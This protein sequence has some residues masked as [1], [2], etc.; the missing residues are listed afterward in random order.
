MSNWMAVT[1]ANTVDGHPIGVM[2]PQIGY[3]QPHII[4]E[5]SV[6][7]SGGTP[8]D[9][10]GRGMAVAGI[11]YVLIGRGTDY[12]WS[13]TSNDS[14]HRRHARI[15]DVQ[16]GRLRALADPGQR[17]PQRRRL[18]LR[19]RRR[20]KGP[21]YAARFYKRT[22]S[23][24]A[25]PTVASIAGLGGSLAPASVHRYVL[26]THYGPVFATATVNGAPV[27][28]SSQ[29]STFFGELDTTAPFALTSTPTV[30]GV[31]SFQHLLNGYSGTFNWLYVDKQDVGYSATGLLPVRNAG[32]SPEL[33][34]WG[35]GNYEWAS[36]VSF[37]QQNPYYFSNY[38]GDVSFP[39]RTVPVAQNGGPLNGGY[40]EWQNYLTYA[41]H[42]QVVNPSQGYILSW[43]NSPAAGWWAADNRPNWGPI[44]RID[45]EPKRF[46]QFPA[47]P[48]P[49]KFEFRQCR[50]DHGGFRLQRS[51]RP[52]AVAAAAA[53]I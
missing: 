38:G 37:L 35:N 32:Q 53:V 44:H 18:S 31:S 17:L 21:Q 46:Q 9:L 26:R 23:W 50:G 15:E 42:P 30:H 33:P 51:A 19:R 34:S 29:R 52:E 49:Q 11:P 12:A 13:A 28:I 1:A 7:S 40:Y 45:T 48:W 41:Q 3:F 36:D 24:T 43:N 20:N 39:S 4:W 16:H 14:D 25:T 10:D 27:A 5:Y 8:T 6:H 22:D 2:G 47:P